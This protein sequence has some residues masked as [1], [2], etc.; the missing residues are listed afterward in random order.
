MGFDYYSLRGNDL[1]LF[2]DLSVEMTHDGPNDANGCKIYNETVVEDPLPY[3]ISAV[4]YGSSALKI[5][6][7]CFQVCIFLYLLILK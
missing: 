4:G 6:S 3:H 7:F 5:T 1:I 2:S